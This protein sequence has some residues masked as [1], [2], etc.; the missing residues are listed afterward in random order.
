MPDPEYLVPDSESED[1]AEEVESDDEADRKLYDRLYVEAKRVIKERKGVFTEE[2]VDVFLRKFNNLAV[3][4]ADQYKSPN[5][6]HAI[7]ELLHGNDIPRLEDILPL[8]KRLVRKFPY[9]LYNLDDQEQNPVFFALKKKQSVLVNHLT[10]YC[11]EKESIRMCLVQALEQPCGAEK[12]KTCLHLALETATKTKPKIAT[13]LVRLASAIALKATDNDNKTPLHYAVDYKSCTTLRTA[14]VKTFIERD[15]EA[16][17][18]H[19]KTSSSQPLETFLDVKVDVQDPTKFLWSAYQEHIATAEAYKKAVAKMKPKE[20]TAD[21]HAKRIAEEGKSRTAALPARSEHDAALRPSDPAKLRVPRDSRALGR[22]DGV[23]TRERNKDKASEDIMDERERLRRQLKEEEER[24]MRDEEVMPPAD[25]RRKV[26]EVDGRREQSRDRTNFAPEDSR[27]V[28]LHLQIA[29]P[30]A[31]VGRPGGERAPNTPI[32]RVP[33]MLAQQEV[34][35]FDYKGLPAEIPGELVKKTFISMKFD[36]VLKYV[37]FTNVTVRRRPTPRDKLKEPGTE[38]GRRDMEFFFDWLYNKGVRHIIKLTVEENG[39]AVH[40]DEAIKTALDKV[41]VEHLDWQKV[42]MDPEVICGISAQAE[43]KLDENEDDHVT[44][45]DIQTDTSTADEA[46]NNK[47]KVLDLRW[48]GSIA[49]LRAWSEPQGLP[50]LQDLQ[51]VNIIVPGHVTD[52]VVVALIDDGVVSLNEYLAGRVLEGKT[53]DYHDGVVGQYYNS[54]KGHGTEM[55]KLILRVCP[56]AKIYP[57]RLKTYLSEDGESKI[58]LKSAAL[59]INAAREKNAAIISM[60]WS[61]PVPDNEHSGAKKLFKDA[62]NKTIKDKRIMFCSSSDKGNFNNKE[63]PSA[64]NPQGDGMF[65]IGA[66]KDDGT[67]FSYVDPNVDYIFPGVKVNSYTAGDRH[68]QQHEITGSSVA[69]ALGAGLAATIIYCFKMGAL[70]TKIAR[71]QRNSQEAM[72]STQFTEEH[73]RS[74]AEYSTMKSAFDKLGFINQARF[75]QVWDL[76]EPSITPASWV[77]IGGD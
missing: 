65:R 31:A 63:Y 50:L 66:A 18:E 4:A 71:S 15:E 22:E 61:I 74:I 28:S 38:P 44:I 47:L 8:V 43:D 35:Y 25:S 26:Q 60:S 37:R 52:D 58:D 54:D 39:G 49:V 55:A 40:S 76:L 69:T 3:K 64:A 32:K 48:S 30:T 57:I 27:Q 19:R 20:P 42:D 68:A 6:L 51:T 56:M 17:L 10:K 34:I 62:V 9:L 36:E 13:K 59:A 73:V 7:V 24:R 75:I 77:P 45:D 14:I 1:D 53:F 41:I 33:T 46:S 11:D 2:D 29:S 72:P 5:L 23:K 12:N 70:A 16:V 67:L 21:G